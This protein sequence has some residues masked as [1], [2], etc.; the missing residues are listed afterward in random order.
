MI[1]NPWV[2][3]NKCPV[4]ERDF[5]AG[6]I[7]VYIVLTINQQNTHLLLVHEECSKLKREYWKV[8]V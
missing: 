7:L 5:E 1:L 8:K 2:L 3:G 6:D 4:C